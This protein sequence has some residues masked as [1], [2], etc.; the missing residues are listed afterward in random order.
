MKA[1]ILSPAASTPQVAALLT[2]PFSRLSCL[3]ACAC[4][5]R[6]RAWRSVCQ[7]LITNNQ[8]HP[9]ICRTFFSFENSLHMCFLETSHFWLCVFSSQPI[10]YMKSR[11]QIHASPLQLTRPLLS[12]LSISPRFPSAPSLRSYA[13]L[14]LQTQ[15][16]PPS[17]FYCSRPHSNLLLH[18][19]VLSDFRCILCPAVVCSDTKRHNFRLFCFIQNRFISHIRV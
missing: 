1:V 13:M 11:K 10:R 12:L 6:E 2:F 15:P 5:A 4:P 3:Q 7:S 8:V 14:P 16:P 17:S 18:L 9:K 19:K